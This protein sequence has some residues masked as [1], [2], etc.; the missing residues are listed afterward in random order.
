VGSS[1][2]FEYNRNTRRWD[3]RQ[4]PTLTDGEKAVL[5]LS[6]Q[7]YTMSEIAARICLSPDTIKKYRQRIF[8]KLDVRNISE[9]IVA[10]TNNKLL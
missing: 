4:M 2:Y 5:T 9:A 3:K 10:A 6:I 8:E 1:E 7:G